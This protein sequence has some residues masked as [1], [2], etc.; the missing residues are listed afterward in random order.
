VTKQTTCVVVL[1]LIRFVYCFQSV[2]GESLHFKE[3]VRINLVNRFLA[4]G[5]RLLPILAWY[6]LRFSSI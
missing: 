2:N 3:N 5:N 1:T 6:L 4:V